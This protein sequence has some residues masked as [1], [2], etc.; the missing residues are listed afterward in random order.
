MARAIV[1]KGLRL[2]LRHT[3]C[4]HIC[5]YCLISGTRKESRL[6]FARFEALAHRFLDWRDSSGRDDLDIGAFVGPAHDYD[7]ETLR[8]VA[9][10]RRRRGRELETLNLGGLRI[11]R[12]QSLIEWIEERRAAGIR[13]FHV[14]LAGYGATHDRWNGRAG[15][16]DYQTTI[17]RLAGERDMV[18]D[19]RLFLT[20]NTL[21]QFDALLN[22]LDGV[23][24]ESRRRYV[25]LF[26]FAGL[27]MRYEGER[28]TEDI[29]DVLPERIAALTRGRFKDWRSEREWIP[30]M[31]ETA[32]QP[33]RLML[34]LD[35]D[36]ANIDELEK[37][38]CDAVFERVERAYQDDY[39]RFPSID[40]LCSKYGDPSGRDVYMMSRDLEG[41]WMSLHA[42]G[43]GMK[44][45]MD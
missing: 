1:G 41:K 34:K 42:R 27:A 45:P 38:S 17:L 7:L 11:R 8:G 4:A 9:R 43:T 3:G 22:F 44:V 15:D 2:S 20:K 32:D 31:R 29:R 5:R 19:E 36:E 23:P 30:I 16:F 14:S 25:T 6:P 26:F 35:V 39:R 33:R 24:G 21:P 10:L 18:R 28:I 40:E 12:G 37:S 13:G